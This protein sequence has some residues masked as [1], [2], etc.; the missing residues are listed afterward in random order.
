MGDFGSEFINAKPDPPLG[1]G[2]RL[3][4]GPK[5]LPPV[6]AALAESANA[7]LNA[8][9]LQAMAN[10]LKVAGGGFLY[11]PPGRYYLGRSS[12]RPVGGIVSQEDADI[13]IP[14]EVTLWFAPAAVLVPLAGAPWVSRRAIGGALTSDPDASAVR[15]EVQGDIVAG[16]EP[17]FDAQFDSAAGSGTLPGGGAGNIDPWPAGRILLTSRRI[18]QVYPEWWGALPRRPLSDAEYRLDIPRTTRA[19]QAAIDAAY[20]R[21]TSPERRLDGSLTGGWNVRPTIPIVAPSTYVIDRPLE[22]LAPSDPRVYP[23]FAG[24]PLSGGGFELRGDRG[25]GTLGL[26]DPTLVASTYE[27]TRFPLA[28]PLLRIDGPEHVR[29]EGVIFDGDLQARGAVSIVPSRREWLTH[30]FEGCTF[31][32]CVGTLLTLDATTAQGPRRDFWNI[33]FTRCRFEPGSDTEV[34]RRIL[35]PD[36]SQRP[37]ADAEYNLV[38]VEL[39][40]EDNAGLAFQNCIFFGVASPVI[41]A[42][43]G[44]F[45]LNETVFH[46]NRAAHPA[47]P[48][49]HTD[50][51]FRHGMDI[52]IEGNVRLGSPERHVPATF[53]ARE[54]ESQSWQFL[55]TATGGGF[56]L[57]RA[58]RSAVVLLNVTSVPV[59]HPTAHDPTS[60]EDLPPSLYWDQPGALGCPL[61]M[62]G[63]RV[64][65]VGRDPARD[66]DPR[67]YPTAVVVAPGMTGDVFT[68]GCSTLSTQAPGD[69]VVLPAVRGQLPRVR[70]LRATTVR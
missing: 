20:T 2:S 67:T 25:L 17:I 43:S 16:V 10:E 5:V 63:C 32:N 36:P 9:T 33:S 46:V 1:P 66:R 68:V 23:W 26:G 54:V 13:V 64:N 49:R 53:T 4:P 52:Y 7:A 22:V 12:V 48:A 60:T 37:I 45:T 65:G 34:S 21:R 29:V 35:R 14:P 50:V 19:F 41:R 18:R 58:D 42:H 15:V 59:S 61:V 56:A 40:L 44:R 39:L 6:G 11:L 28:G 47:L 31:R 55:G 24:P 57:D 8:R 51:D 62:V 30:A 27:P 38:A 3:V 69:A 70:R